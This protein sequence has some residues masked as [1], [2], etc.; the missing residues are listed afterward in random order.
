MSKERSLQ[1]PLQADAETNAELWDNICAMERFLG[2]ALGLSPSASFLSREPETSFIEHGVVNSR[3]YLI[4]LVG[5]IGELQHVESKSSSE[6]VT[7]E[8]KVLAANLIRRL[9]DLESR[10]SPSWWATAMT[11]VQPD[12]VAQFLH[13]CILLRV[14]LPFAMQQ[15][16]CEDQAQ[17]WRTC[18]Q[19]SLAITKLYKLLRRELPTG[20]FASRILDLQ[21]IPAMTMLLVAPISANNS[22]VQG[23][24]DIASLSLDVEEVIEIMRL[25]ADYSTSPGST[26]RI[27]EMFSA[28]RDFVTENSLTTDLR[29]LT[30]HVP[31]LGRVHIKVT[32]ASQQ[33]TAMGS[34][35]LSGTRAPSGNP[36][37]SRNSISFDFEPGQVVDLDLTGWDNDMFD[38]YIIDVAE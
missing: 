34:V 35:E 15:T 28:L 30:L 36:L 27:A 29:E 31:L 25:K 38:S 17:E 5:L 32:S 8:L 1:S 37:W 6:G 7:D 10:T 13:H 26:G 33:F 4:S 11:E 9:D 24:L 21:A 12:H 22:A 18:I 20:I 23:Y 14:Q 19:T 3:L 16:H 2:M